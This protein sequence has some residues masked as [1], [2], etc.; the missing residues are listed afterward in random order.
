MSTPFVGEIRVVGFNFA[1]KGWATCDGQIIAIQQN[2][3]LFSLLGVNFGGNGTSNFGLPNFQG[4][5]P[6]CQ[7]NGAGLTA[8]QVG[9]TAGVPNV[10]L[11][12]NN[13]PAHNHNPFTGDEEPAQDLN[14]A[15]DLYAGAAKATYAPATA[16]AYFTPNTVQYVGNSQPHDNMA[17]YQVLLYIIALQGIY[18]ARN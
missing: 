4:L 6:V 5:A 7:G 2:T 18:P 16:G 3:A 8:Y 9:S 12:A 11:Q 17:P 1:P 10:T 13:L 14:P 15:G